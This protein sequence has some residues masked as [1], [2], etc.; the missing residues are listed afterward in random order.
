MTF[1]RQQA[2]DK[3]AKDKADGLE[4][5]QIQ[6]GNDL[7]AQENRKLDLLLEKARQEE[8]KDILHFRY[9]TSLAKAAKDRADTQDAKQELII[10]GEMAQGD[11]KVKQ[12]TAKARQDEDRDVALF[13]REIAQ[14]RDEK[15]KEDRLKAHQDALANGAA[16][17]GNRIIDQQNEKDKLN[18]D[19]DVYEF[20]RQLA[21]HKT[22]MDQDARDALKQQM[23]SR[24]E[25]AASDREIDRKIALEKQDEQRDIMTFRRDT[26]LSA[27]QNA[28]N[29]RTLN[30]ED[31]LKRAEADREN[32]KID[33]VFLERAQLE[34]EVMILRGQVALSVN[35]C[36]ER[37]IS[38]LD[39]DQIDVEINRDTI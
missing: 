4:L 31:Q 26:A 8:D 6:H 7:I 20:R 38:V 23:I 32:R 30:H 35:Q 22:Q 3:D 19:N 1:R 2:I 16:A 21:L 27:A 24:G 9:D 12:M 37:R 14:H 39:V 34:K 17:Q 5:K 29:E 15:D 10:K 28:A 18:Q 36:P 25:A 13:R 33:K 11:R